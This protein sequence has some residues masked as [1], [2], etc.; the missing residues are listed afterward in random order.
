MLEHFFGISRIA[1]ITTKF[2]EYRRK[3]IFA[4]EVSP[5][6]KPFFL[7]KGKEKKFFVRLT[8]STRQISD[9]EEIINYWI[10]KPS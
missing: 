4:I 8:A 9:P 10:D 2:Y 5:S 6:R 3:E 7:K 1:Y